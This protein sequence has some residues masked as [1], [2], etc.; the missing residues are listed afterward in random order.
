WEI[1]AF[2]YEIPNPFYPGVL[3]PTV[4]F[5]ALFLWPFLE[6]RFTGDRGPHHLLERARDHPVRTAFVVT[7]LSFFVLLQLAASND[8]L[9]HRLSVSVA[10]ITWTFR[11]MVPVLPLV[12]GYATYRL[13]TALKASG[14]ERFAQLAMRPLLQPMRDR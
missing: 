10:A 8:L 11:I 3:V 9:A 5:G 2:S 1:R 7:A 12:F 13:M 6:A 4:T 14:V